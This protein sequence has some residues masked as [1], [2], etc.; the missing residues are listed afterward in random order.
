MRAELDAAR[1]EAGEAAA[2]QHEFVAAARAR[3]TLLRDQVAESGGATAAAASA[4]A[5]E[6]AKVF[7]EETRDSEPDATVSNL[8][9]TNLP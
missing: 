8:P 7:G 4:A 2:R 1:T 5:D 9:P 3:I 6:A